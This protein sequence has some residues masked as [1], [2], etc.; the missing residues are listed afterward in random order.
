MTVTP[1]V[2][3][4]NKTIRL[5][6]LTLTATLL[7][8]KL[9]YIYFF[10][11]TQNSV[12]TEKVY[13][14]VLI[15]TSFPFLNTSAGTSTYSIRILVGH[16]SRRTL[17]LARSDERWLLLN[18]RF[19]CFW[20]STVCAGISIAL[21]RHVGHMEQHPGTQEAAG[22]SEREAAAAAERPSTTVRW[23]VHA[24]F[25]YLFFFFGVFSNLM[26]QIKQKLMSSMKSL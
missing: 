5:W 22:L 23:Y 10:P 25:S 4:L 9:I 13:T 18:Q 11:E 1:E 24:T 17:I 2:G 14:N 7:Y 20:V 16:F 3:V 12:Y 19:D 21:R 15:Y 26:E 8:L 6:S